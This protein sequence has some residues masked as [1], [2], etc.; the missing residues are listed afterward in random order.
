M[1]YICSVATSIPQFELAQSEI[2]EFVRNIFPRSEREISRLLPVFENAAIE[3]RQFVVP[4]DWFTVNHSFQKRNAFYQQEAIEHSIQAIDACLTDKSFL[5]EPIDYNKIDCIIFV[6]S[7]GISTPSIDA[8]IINM[9]NFREDVVRIPLWGLGCAGGASGIARAHDWLTSNPDKTALVVCVELCSLT[10][11][12]DDHKKSN[13]I[14][15]A[16]FGDG[17]AAA[18]MVGNESSLLKLCNHMSP[19]VQRTS[20]R[21][22]KQTLDVMGWDITNDG[23]EV[24]FAKSIPHLVETF[25]KQ[26]VFDFLKEQQLT[27]DDLPF[28]VAHPGG[29]KVLEAFERVLNVTS[30]VFY[31]SY[32]TLKNHGN[33]SSPTVLYVLKAWM[34]EQRKQGDKSMLASLGPGFSSELVSLEWI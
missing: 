17:I 1:S 25:W 23:F 11:Q 28:I 13:F 2:K 16:L 8:H 9:L 12:K 19:M 14:G 15:T 20:S 18:L 21:I 27:V 29:K 4:K 3:N 33:M 32:E 34:S 5:S 7:T 10:F 26:H 31:H 24:V 22:K 6:S 30:N